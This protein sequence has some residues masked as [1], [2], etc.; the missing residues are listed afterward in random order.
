MLCELRINNFIKMCKVK[1][2]YAAMT[3]LNEK[4]FFKPRP[5]KIFLVLSYFCNFHP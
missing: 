5:E 4:C 1:K 3:S 2:Y